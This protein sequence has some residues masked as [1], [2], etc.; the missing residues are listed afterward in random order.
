MIAASCYGR[1]VAAHTRYQNN[2]EPSMK[3]QLGFYEL[4]GAA[5]ALNA[6]PAFAAQQCKG[7]SP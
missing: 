6:P 4:F 2:S 1:F 3:E 7:G 5:V